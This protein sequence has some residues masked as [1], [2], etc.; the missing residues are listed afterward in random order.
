ML[1]IGLLGAGMIGKIHV[2]GF[3]SMNS[4]IARYTAVC[5][6][7][8]TKRNDFAQRYNFRVFADLDGMLA[9][10]DIDIVDLCLPSFM[11]EQFAVRIV[12]AKKHILI[13]KPI[14]FTL[15]AARNIFAAARENG[16]RTMVAQVIRFWPEYAKVKEICDSGALGD[17]VT[18]Y[19]GRLGQMVTWV[20]WYKD[21]AKSGETL[22]N[23]TQHDI[24]FLHYLLGKPVSAYSA[25]TCDASNN[26]ND[27][28]NIFRFECGANAMVD[29]S[30]SMTAGYPFTMR[31]RVLG[32]RGTL[33]FTYT[34]GENIDSESASMLMWYR[35]GEKGKKVEVED[36]DPYGKEIEYFAGCIITGKDPETVSEQSVMQVLASI[37]A[38]RESLA[39]GEMKL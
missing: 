4:K 19:A 35:P 32:T 30:L 27:V 25:G 10:P 38:A 23:L 2:D 3:L 21:P 24:D 29:G 31:M 20:D 16:V 1:Q 17:I 37:L 11:H 5:D 28:M 36:Y 34:A 9:D 6:I 39:K 8:E 7:D 14:A 18:V 26:Y 33:E 22:M 13:E 12:K 15:E